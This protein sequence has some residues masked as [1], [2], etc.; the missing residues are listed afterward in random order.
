MHLLDRWRTLWPRLW[1]RLWLR[2]WERCGTDDEPGYPALRRLLGA[3]T[4]AASR[5][6]A[7]ARALLPLVPP[8][9]RASSTSRATPVTTRRSD[10]PTAPNEPASTTT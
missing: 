9:I 10:R 6:L 1:L 5:S 2:L 7:C 8:S 4:A 3:V